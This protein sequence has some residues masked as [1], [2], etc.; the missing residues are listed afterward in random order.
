[1]QLLTSERLEVCATVRKLI[2]EEWP[3]LAHKL[4]PRGPP[5]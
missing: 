2:L 3:E 1:M 5:E 4:A